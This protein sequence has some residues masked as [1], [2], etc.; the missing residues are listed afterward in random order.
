MHS[1]IL[2]KRNYKI[3]LRVI[4]WLIFNVIY[5]YILDIGQDEKTKKVA[6]SSNEDTI[7]CI[8]VSNCGRFLAVATDKKQ[9]FVFR[10]NKQ[11]IEFCFDL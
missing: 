3:H 7:Y 2:N 4:E 1:C 5:L 10:D 9:L 11:G 6:N 8:C